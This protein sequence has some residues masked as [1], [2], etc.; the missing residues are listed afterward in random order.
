MNEASQ[1][2]CD[3]HFL[4]ERVSCRET[5]AI[6]SFWLPSPLCTLLQLYVCVCVALQ[7][8]V[9]LKKSSHFIFFCFIVQFFQ[10][11]DWMKVQSKG[12]WQRWQTHWVALKIVYIHMRKTTLQF[13][14]HVPAEPKCNKAAATLPAGVYHCDDSPKQEQKWHQESAGNLVFFFCPPPQLYCRLISYQTRQMEGIKSEEMR[15]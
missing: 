15:R 9:V 6:F 8:E 5:A 1:S 10:H 2:Q 13:C 12:C 4:V 11:Q 7:G 3:A 14:F